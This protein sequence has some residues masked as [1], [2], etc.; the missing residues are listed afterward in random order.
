MIENMTCF[1]KT[2]FRNWGSEKK[3]GVHA[4][5]YRMMLIMVTELCTNSGESKIEIV[6]L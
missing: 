1:G 2:A 3:R 5:G 6:R 4:K